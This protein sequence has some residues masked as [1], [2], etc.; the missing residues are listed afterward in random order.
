MPQDA[1]SGTEQVFPW[2]LDSIG[3]KRAQFQ[4]SCW[5]GLRQISDC[6]SKWSLPGNAILLIMK[7]RMASIYSAVIMSE[8]EL[9]I[10]HSQ[11]C[12]RFVDEPFAM[13]KVM[14]G[15]LAEVP[16]TAEPAQGHRPF[17]A[18]LGTIS[19]RLCPLLWELC[20]TGTSISIL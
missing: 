8:A 14:R 16:I 6:P 1:S 15:Q 12:P 13:S 17:W 20:E 3:A 11:P 7:R 9:R 18:L 10:L 4:K 5:F 2:V 19:S